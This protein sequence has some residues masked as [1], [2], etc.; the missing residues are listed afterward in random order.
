MNRNGTSELVH[1]KH[2]TVDEVL[3]S[4]DAVSM[5]SVDRLIAKILK[6]EPAISII[7]PSE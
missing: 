5:E 4:I 6:A 7:G 3:K 1:R 2:R